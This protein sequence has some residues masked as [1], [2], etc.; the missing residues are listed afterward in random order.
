MNNIVIKSIDETNASE[1]LN[2]IDR[3]SKERSKYNINEIPRPNIKKEDFTSTLYYVKAKELYRE[4]YKKEY[5]MLTDELKRLNDINT[6]LCIEN[7][8]K[9]DEKAKEE[10]TYYNADELQYLKEKE[11]IRKISRK[12][13]Q[14][15][16]Y[17]GNKEKLRKQTLIKKCKEYENKIKSVANE[18]NKHLITS[19]RIINPLCICGKRCDVINFKNFEKHPKLIKHQ[20]FKSIIRLVHYE[21]RNKRIKKVID[22]I[23]ND[24]IYFKKYSRTDKEHITMSGKRKDKVEKTTV[25]INKTDKEIIKF[26]NDLVGEIDENKYKIREPSINKVN[27]SRQ[28]KDKINILK[29]REVNLA[30]R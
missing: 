23:N 13:T 26:Y 12:E 21:R 1:L 27:Y 9:Q 30:K 6:N 28:Y 7:K 5:Q 29:I 10:G 8:K 11:E 2:E 22:K 18:H 16:Y 14:K 25:L 4:T 24:L 3:L 15:K 17:E 19:K 20:L